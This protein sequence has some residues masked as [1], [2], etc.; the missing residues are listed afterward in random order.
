[1]NTDLL[2]EFGI[3]IPIVQAP[4]AGVSTPALA[5]AVSNAG[6]LG[7][8]SIG[9][10]TVNEAR[11]A[12]KELQAATRSPFNIN[13]FCHESPI[14]DPQRSRRCA[15][16]MQSGTSRSSAAESAQP[17]WWP[18]K[19]AAPGSDLASRRASA[20]VTI[21]KTSRRTEAPAGA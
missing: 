6:A 2:K 13:V 5:V 14:H 15:Q 11:V 3:Q 17:V 4:M 7:S 16:L 18:P 20:R 21:K 8:L 10:M 9:A 1:M 12:V 19:H